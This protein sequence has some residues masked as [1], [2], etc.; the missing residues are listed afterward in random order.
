M[1]IYLF[2]SAPWQKVQA[3]SETDPNQPGPYQVTKET[4]TISR[5]GI[6]SMETDIYYPSVLNSSTPVVILL[7]GF[8]HN[9]E[10]QSGNAEHL[11]SWGFITVVPN[12]KYNLL[13]P[14][15]EE[16]EMDVKGILDYIQEQNSDPSSVFSQA[17]LEKIGI[18]GHSAGG[19][20][21]VMLTA[22]DL[23]IKSLVGLDA[24]LSG[25][26]PGSDL[27]WDPRQEG[28]LISVPS[29]FLLAPPQTC[30]NDHDGGILAY[31][32]VS[33]E[34]KAKY[35]L[36]DGNHC[37]FMNADEFPNSLCYSLCGG[38]YDEGR[39][40]LGRKYLTAWFGYFLRE[41]NDFQPYLF[42]QYAQED[43][44]QGL[45]ILEFKTPSTVCLDGEKG[46]LNCDQ[47][48]KVDEG[49]LNIL[50]NNWHPF[51]PAFDPP[52]GQASPDLDQDGDVDELD[53]SKLLFHWPGN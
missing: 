7:H 15:P 52:A 26:M 3:Q 40:R 6:N 24:V 12:L 47:A 37:D 32:Y 44:D 30:N 51:G 53:L 14:N 25:G 33:S 31:D 13:E 39:L 22:H 38:S 36:V 21:A 16:R 42:G 50:L 11:S 35:T 20:T 48:G 2:L 34:S 46:N 45:I 43:E 19:L 1:V 41:I 5:P 17:E 10:G 4:M 28:H 23:R 49:D 27:S 9:K 8:Q 18:A 29:A